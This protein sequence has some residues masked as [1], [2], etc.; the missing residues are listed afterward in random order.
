MSK[1]DLLRHKMVMVVVVVWEGCS[2]SRF[3]SH[4]RSAREPYACTL[5]VALPA[6]GAAAEASRAQT[7][8]GL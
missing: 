5:R 8:S 2:L 7:G 4:G 6:A 3:R 1:N